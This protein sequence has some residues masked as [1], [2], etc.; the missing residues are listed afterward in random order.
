MDPR[1][2]IPP[3]WCSAEEIEENR[4]F[5]VEHSG[6]LSKDVPRGTIRGRFEKG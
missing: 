1:Y 6:I 5:H 2:A 3:I 4:V